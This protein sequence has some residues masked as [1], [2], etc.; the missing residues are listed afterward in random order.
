ML[1]TII[2]NFIS[3][4][5]NILG[6]RG[7]FIVSTILGIILFDILRI[8]RKIILKNLTIAFGESKTLYEKIKIGR[9]STISFIQT[10]LEL[11]TAKK[12]FARTKF[13]LKND[14]IL[15]ELMAKND[16]VYAI[17]I[18]MG[19]WEYLCHI[20]SNQFA[21]IH[22]VVKPIGKG[23][24]AKWVERMRASIGFRLIDRKG[25][26]SS[27]TQI[28][29]ALSKK[30]IIGFIVDQKRPR[31]ELLPFFGKE[32]STNNSLAKLWL[33]RKAPVIPVMIKRTK[34]DTHEI[35][36]FQE[37]EMK[38]DKSV[39]IEKNITENTLR[40]N[41]VVEEMIRKN[42]EEYFWMHNRWG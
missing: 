18:H 23:A 13:I 31:G 20:G 26:E 3:F 14:H 21:P 37:F 1:L 27:T 42:P 24:L 6:H 33:R 7:I 30:E 34:I 11:F 29:N 12:L 40:I 28:F 10:A 17:C 16:G 5:L 38:D 39:S 19:N 22:V 15:R 25:K 2:L 32:A 36:F 41:T 9:K 35:T 4:C 8:R